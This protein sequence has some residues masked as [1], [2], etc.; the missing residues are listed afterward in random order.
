MFGFKIV[1][2]EMPEYFRDVNWV[3][4]LVNLELRIYVWAEERDLKFFDK[5]MLFKAMS[6][7]ESP[8]KNMYRRDGKG[9]RLISK[10]SPQITK[11]GDEEQR[12]KRQKEN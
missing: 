12:T 8:G 5:K 9:L 3:V 4:G 10:E 1:Y 2:F 6:I 11:R 7:Y